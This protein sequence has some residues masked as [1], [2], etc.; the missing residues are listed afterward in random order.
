MYQLVALI[1]QDVPMYTHTRSYASAMGM[2]ATCFHL[3]STSRD[4]FLQ[5]PL[6]HQFRTNTSFTFSPP[7]PSISTTLTTRRE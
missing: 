6:L 5:F 7:K 2:R 4:A 1:Q 3:H